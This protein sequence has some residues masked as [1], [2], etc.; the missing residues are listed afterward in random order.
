M[1]SSAAAAAAGSSLRAPKLPPK[2]AAVPSSN[3]GEESTS[4]A[5]LVF[6]FAPRKSRTNASI[7]GR[8]YYISKN[9]SN[10]NSYHDGKCIGMHC[11]PISSVSNPVSEAAANLK[12][13]ITRRCGD[14]R[15]EETAPRVKS[16][17][18]AA[19]AAVADRKIPLVR[20]YRGGNKGLYVVARNSF[21]LLLNCSAWLCLGP[22]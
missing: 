4:S 20:M 18:A 12:V 14:W 17:R 22:A 21:L 3:Y 19:A 7:L 8:Y 9:I 6:G 2:T 16:R 15:G 11:L 13:A 10:C 1:S 5:N